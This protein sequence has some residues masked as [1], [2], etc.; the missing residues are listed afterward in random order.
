MLFLRLYRIACWGAVLVLALLSL[1]PGSA[2][3][4]TGLLSPTAEHFLA[5]FLTGILFGADNRGTT[6][7]IAA[8]VSLS[9]AS[10]IFELLQ[11]FVPGREPR[12]LDFIVSSAGATCGVCAV[13][14]AGYCLSRKKR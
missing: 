3:P 7:R 14:T 4:H 12:M 2:R 10:G 6:H 8:T 5:Y 9:I 1:V 11:N 13:A